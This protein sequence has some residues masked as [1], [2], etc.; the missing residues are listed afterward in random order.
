[1]PELPE[2]ETIVRS[3]RTYITGKKIERITLC[4]KNN[5]IFRYL[6]RGTWQKLIGTRIVGIHRLGKNII[7][8]LSNKKF[9]TFHLMMSGRILFNPK[10]SHICDRLKIKLSGD[11]VLVFR[12]PRKFGWCRVLDTFDSL[13][14][15]D[16]LSVSPARFKKL[17]AG[18]GSAVKSFLLNQ[19][20]IAGTGNIYAD[21]ILWY[22]GISPLKAP[23]S[24]TPKETEKLYRM[25]RR[26]LFEGIKYGGTS[27]R[28][29]QKPDGSLGNYYAVRAVY[30]RTGEKCRRDGSIIQRIVVG[31]R[32]T[33]FCP[34]H[35]K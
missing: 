10:E 14:G 20:F 9:L 23:N 33:H 28:D 31:Q 6:S 7:I 18:R 12:D 22:A 25:M 16:A 5:R 15:E 4:G 29:Y 3:L 17:L 32:S 35:Q 34:L 11:N 26:V 30:H 8:S 2:V 13:V 24:L 19:K 1:M 27:S 21:E